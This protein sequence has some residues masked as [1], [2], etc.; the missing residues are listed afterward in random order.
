M[1]ISLQGVSVSR[2]I[3]I[4]QV[5]LIQHDQ[6]DVREYSIR[7]TRLDD[8]ISRLNDAI[9]EARLQLRAIREHI[10][11][12]TSVDISAFIDTHLLML[13]DNALTEEPKRIIR[14]RLCNA[15][16]ALKFKSS[17]YFFMM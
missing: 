7:S 12:S 4:G 16:W 15:E 5:H 10:P 13:E 17:T 1:T 6:L 8:E 14:E 11:V 9:A 2:G 3:A